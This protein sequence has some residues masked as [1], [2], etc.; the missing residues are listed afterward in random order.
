MGD[1]LTLVEKAESQ[2]DAE[3]AKILE[4][5]I[6][7]NEF[8]FD[9][10]LDQLKMIKKMGSLKDLLGLIPGMDKQLKNVYLDDKAFSMV[11]A[12]IL[13]M[14]KYERQ[15]PK[16]INGSRRMRIAKGSGSQV[17]DVNRLLKQFDEMSNMM[18]A[19]T[20]GNK[21]RFMRGINMAGKLPG[22]FGK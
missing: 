13:S 21:S 16:V 12:M 17:Q 7:N 6:R 15:N 14:T 18:K 2:F 3:E 11:E 22:R 8:N 9:D 5:K 4:E 10:F 19:L 1:I 20:R